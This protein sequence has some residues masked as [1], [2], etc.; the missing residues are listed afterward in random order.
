MPEEIGHWQ[1]ERAC[2][3]AAGSRAR[4]Q[5]LSGSYSDDIG[6]IR[7]MKALT[8]RRS[9][10]WIGKGS[11]NGGPLRAIYW[12]VFAH[13]ISRSLCFWTSKLSKHGNTGK[14]AMCGYFLLE[15]VDLPCHVCWRVNSSS[16]SFLF[17]SVLP[18]T[19]L[20]NGNSH[21]HCA[22]GHQSLS[23]LGTK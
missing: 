13:L 22:N 17:F 12:D 7:R 3:D 20:R 8:T 23:M 18:L 1:C 21:W 19:P 10:L 15:K 16:M 14:S 4:E 2:G 5:V 11:Y 6:M 9:L